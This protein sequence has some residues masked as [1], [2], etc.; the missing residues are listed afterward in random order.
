MEHPDDPGKDEAEFCELHDR[1]PKKCGKPQAGPDPCIGCSAKEYL[2]FRP[3]NPATEYCFFLH[4]YIEAFRP[5][6]D[7]ISWKDMERI[8]AFIM[9]KNQHEAKIW[10]KGKND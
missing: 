8:Q 4:S 2:D 9:A 3:E 1:D 10:E 7:R 5:P 6:P